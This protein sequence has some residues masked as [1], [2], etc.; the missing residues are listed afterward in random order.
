M[1]NYMPERIYAKVKD[2][3]KYKEA[4]KL[5]E[6]TYLVKAEAAKSIKAYEEL[7]NTTRESDKDFADKYLGMLEEVVTR[8]CPDYPTEYKII[9]EYYKSKDELIKIY[10]DEKNDHE[11]RL[12]CLSDIINLSYSD[13][14]FDEWT[15]KFL[16]FFGMCT[17]DEVKGFSGYILLKAMHMK[18]YMHTYGFAGKEITKEMI[19]EAISFNKKTLSECL[20]V[21]TNK[22]TVYNAYMEA[23]T[24]SLQNLVALTDDVDLLL[25]YAKSIAD[26]DSGNT[27]QYQ[28]YSFAVL[29][30]QDK[31]N[32]L[33]LL[34]GRYTDFVHGTIIA[35]NYISEA[36]KDVNKLARGLNY[37][38]KRNS[39]DFICLLRK[40][41][42]LKALSPF[43]R[44]MDMFSIK[45]IPTDDYNYALSDISGEVKTAYSENIYTIVDRY[46]DSVDKFLSD[47][48]KV[49]QDFCKIE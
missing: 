24:D 4:I 5:L 29:L 28:K 17:D 33:Y 22:D 2:D 48:N 13:T 31:K 41:L 25:Y 38:D 11:T 21:D 1:F 44:R 26:E 19:D 47:D 36:Y 49:L 34:T 20:A 16:E 7:L 14:T 9:F 23:C 32:D 46:R 37:Y 8:L 6:D 43:M 3:D 10:E 30:L 15:N 18:I 45:N 12:I 27:Y 40:Y 35:M 39:M 42:K